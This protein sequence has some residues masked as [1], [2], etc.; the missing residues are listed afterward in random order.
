MANLRTS[1]RTWLIPGLLALALG[2]C[3]A[4]TVDQRQFVQTPKQNEVFWVDY[5]HTAQFAPA[6]EGLSAAEAARLDAFLRQIGAS[7]Q[8]TYVIDPGGDDALSLQRADV[9]G[10]ALRD[11]LPTIR[12]VTQRRPDGP[13]SNQARL[14]VGR[15]VVITPN[16]GDWS[17]PSGTDIFNGE[18][19]E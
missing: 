6:Q 13:N 7:F 8:D 3:T 19:F 1:R 9:L 16:C 10:A 4:N 17:K 5:D 2:A 11:R 18:R 12:P 15:Y 14:F